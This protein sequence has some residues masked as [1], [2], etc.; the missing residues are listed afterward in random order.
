MTGAPKLRS[1]QIL[2][3]LERHVPRGVY[4]GGSPACVLSLLTN[5]RRIRLRR[6]GRHD[7]LC[8]RDPDDADARQS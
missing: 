1:V 6:G 5:N 3:E 2:E 4:A 7:R 8:R